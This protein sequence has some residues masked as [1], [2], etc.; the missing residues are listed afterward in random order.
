MRALAVGAEAEDSH[1]YVSYSNG[2]IRKHSSLNETYV[3]RYVLFIL[4]Q[5]PRN[6]V[7]I[8]VQFICKLI[9]LSAYQL[10]LAKVAADLSDTGI[11]EL[12]FSE[13]EMTCP[14]PTAIFVQ[15]RLC[16]SMWAVLR[17]Y[18]DCHVTIG[19]RKNCVLCGNNSQLFTFHCATPSNKM[20]L[21][22][23]T[24]VHR[25]PIEQT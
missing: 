20:S 6:L 15:I 10:L 7:G 11:C 23:A 19:K 17:F 16:G 14:L 2:I 12:W 24:I 3:T 21:I 1:L 25:L 22:L 9:L 5:S 18:V 13:I 4:Q 8:S